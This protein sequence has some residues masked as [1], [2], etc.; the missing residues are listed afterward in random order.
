MSVRTGWSSIV[1]MAGLWLMGAPGAEASSM[2]VASGSV[3]D[4]SWLAGHWRGEGLGGE[5]E[6]IWSE[7]MAGTMVG[8]FRLMKDG[9]VQFYELMVIAPDN[10]GVVLKVKHFTAEFVG[11]EDKEGA[12]VFPL[13]SV[14]GTR[15]QFKGLSMVRKGDELV[16][17]VRMKSNDGT[18]R[19]EPFRMT[20]YQPGAP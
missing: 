16:V 14:A 12:V 3:S 19:E 11:W 10:D 13:E 8:S 18:I 5:C 20:R 4:F 15:A 17:T 1:I 7:P 9:E 2:G 6:E